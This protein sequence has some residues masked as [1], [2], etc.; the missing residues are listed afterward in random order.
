MHLPKWTIA[1]SSG[2][3]LRAIF[4]NSTSLYAISFCVGFALVPELQFL[5]DRDM[6]VFGA[7]VFVSS[8]L[9][10]LTCFPIALIASSIPSSR[11]LESVIPNRLRFSIL[12]LL[13]V[14][15]VFALLFVTINHS[16]ILG[17][18]CVVLGTLGVIAYN[19]MKHYRGKSAFTRDSTIAD[20]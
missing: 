16:R 19:T 11:P 10:S 12:C 20:P 4:S 14:T 7:T 6:W 3:V 1:F 2:I 5:V 8:F 9:W 15:C 17:L 13:L 18:P